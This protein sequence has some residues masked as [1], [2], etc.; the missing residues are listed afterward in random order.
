MGAN[1][2]GIHPPHLIDTNGALTP[3][4]L[5]PFCA[6]QS[7]FLGHPRQDLPFTACDKFRPTVLQ[8]QLCY[9]LDLSLIATNRTKADLREGLL[10][11]IDPG[12]YE[13]ENDEPSMKLDTDG[14]KIYVNTLESFTGLKSGSYAMSNLKKMTGTENFKQ[15]P[16]DTKHCQLD[17]YEKCQADMFLRTVQDECG[18]VPWSLTTALH[19]EVV[20]TP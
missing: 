9:S 20:V 7:N 14:F 1:E 11:M 16:D 4:A 18:C 19:T 15:L 6:Y 5:I 10:L 2:V 13:D 12:R 8:G 3:N 17:T